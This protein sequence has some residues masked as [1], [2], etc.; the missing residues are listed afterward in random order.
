MQDM[1]VTVG[2]IVSG[3]IDQLKTGDSALVSKMKAAWNVA[4]RNIQST[5]FKMETAL[6]HRVLV[7]AQSFPPPVPEREPYVES[8]PP[9]PPPRKTVPTSPPPPPPAPP[10]RD[11]SRI[12]VIRAVRTR[13]LP[14]PPTDSLPTKA[15]SL[16][17]TLS[18]AMDKRRLFVKEDDVDD[19]SVVWE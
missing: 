4:L 2:A 15:A 19:S 17:A 9:I 13:V 6:A 12:G 8:V 5:V 16:A 7:W 10:I 1:K 18:A 14:T 11:K 3:F